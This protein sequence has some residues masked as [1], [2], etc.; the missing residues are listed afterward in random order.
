MER[1]SASQSKAMLAKPFLKQ[2][3]GSMVGCS[4]FRLGAAAALPG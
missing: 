3:I 1:V 4:S 2:A